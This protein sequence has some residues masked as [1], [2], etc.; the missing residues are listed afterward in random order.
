MLLY[1][2]IY[3]VRQLGIPMSG[4]QL[5]S[6]LS[7]ALIVIFCPLA[8]ALSDR[9]G[10]RIVVLPATIIYAVVVWLTVQH[11]LAE[12]SLSRL[13][14]AQVATSLVMA[15]IWGPTPVLLMELFPVGVR[16]TGVG[17]IYNVAVAL[18]GGLAPFAITWLIAATG[19]KMSPVYYVVISA[20]VGVLGLLLLRERRIVHTDDEKGV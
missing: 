15:F 8:G 14:L 2:P 10:R 16:S 5:S 19:D 7:T 6:V 12:P 13:I 1:I 3:A 20:L 17:L 9:V 18:F 4:A 11:L